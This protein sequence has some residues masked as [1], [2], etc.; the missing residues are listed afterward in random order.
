[1]AWPVAKGGICARKLHSFGMLSNLY[2]DL[3][4]ARIIGRAIRRGVGNGIRLVYII[5][6]S[7]RFCPVVRPFSSANPIL[8]SVE[9]W[10]R[11]PGVFPAGQ[12]VKISD[13]LLGA[14]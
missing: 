6:I 3:V 9:A 1:M 10:F 2:I 12:K 14:Q 5:N 4:T 8:S 13:S 11:F 7:T